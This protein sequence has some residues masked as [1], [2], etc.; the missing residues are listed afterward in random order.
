MLKLNRLGANVTTLSIPDGLE[1]M[2]SYNTPVAAFVPGRGYLVTSTKYSRTTSKHINV[3][4]RNAGAV[5]AASKTFVPQGELNNLL[6][7]GLYP[8]IFFMKAR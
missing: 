3:Y 7:P 6:H 2:Y 4:V 5:G 8:D 1:V